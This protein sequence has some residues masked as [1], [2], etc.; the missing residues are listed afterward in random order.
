MLTW[1]W[2]GQVH[3]KDESC[4]NNKELC[5]T[6]RNYKEFCIKNDE[7]CRGTWKLQRKACVD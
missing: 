2:E 6:T 3:R 1:V 7:F 5:I 4:I